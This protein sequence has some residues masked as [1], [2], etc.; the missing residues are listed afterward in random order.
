VTAA[1]QANAEI[2][3]LLWQNAVV[4]AVFMYVSRLDIVTIN[5]TWTQRA[6]VCH[7]RLGAM[8]D[9]RKVIINSVFDVHVTVHLDKFV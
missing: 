5:N 4:V 1:W 9:L 8:A 2:V 3:P 7:C 6:Q